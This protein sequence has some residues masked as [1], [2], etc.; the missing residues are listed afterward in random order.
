MGE[1]VNILGLAKTL[2]SL[3]GRQGI[4]IEFTGLRPGE[5]LAEALFDANDE[6]RTTAHPLL[7]AVDVPPLDG[8]P[9]LAALVE[10]ATA[11]AW[12]RAV[13]ADESPISIPRALA[14]VES[15]RAAPT[16]QTR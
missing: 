7:T 1:Q 14:L 10:P 9:L 3:S 15:S 16:A 11:A 12:M 8:A 4:E 6:S 13:A 2:I 5:K